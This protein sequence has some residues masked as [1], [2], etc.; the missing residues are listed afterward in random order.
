[1]KQ[2]RAG[3]ERLSLGLCLLLWLSAG[4]AAQ[5]PDGTAGTQGAQKQPSPTFRVNVRLVNVFA[6]VTDARGAPVADLTKADFRVLEDVIPQTI[7]VFDQESELPLSIA[8]AVDTSL[9]TM[10]DFKL[11]V[12]SAKKFAHSIMRPVYHLSV[13]E[14]T[15]NINQLTSF[16]SDLTTIDRAIDNLRVGAGTSLYDA[17]FLSAD[18]LMSR[19]GR[20]VLMLITDGGDTTSSADYNAALRRAQQAEAIVYSII[21]VPAEADAGRNLGGEHALIQISK[22]T[23]RKHYY[24]DNLSE[25][26][27]AVR[28]SSKEPRTHY[29]IG[30]YPNRQVSDSPFRRIQVQVIK[31][32]SDNGN[33]QVR[34]RAGYYT[35]AGR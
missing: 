6:T 17:I 21:V 28:Q 31:K 35:A 22:D 12:T 14:V 30:Y 13:F 3:L 32:D 8:L 10:R 34:H 9:S 24:A 5:G 7:S 25:L 19:D 2:A 23:G 29:L 11:E 20:R 26:D 1:M 33:Y 27:N 15:E 18:A 16:T 4:A